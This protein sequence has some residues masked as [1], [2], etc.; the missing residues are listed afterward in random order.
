MW[1][2]Q[3]HATALAASPYT[4]PISGRQFA[5]VKPRDLLR[6]CPNDPKRPQWG[7]DDLVEGD[8]IITDDPGPVIDLRYVRDESFFSKFDVM[9]AE[10]L[11]C[12]IAVETADEMTQ[13]NVKKSTLE[14]QYKLAI[15]DARLVNAIEAYANIEPDE[16]E[17]VTCRSGATYGFGYVR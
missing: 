17:W 1:H 16:D 15:A 4:L 10:A 6:I 5:Y 11:A 9:F 7:P 2:Q 3:P 12:K 8:L 14:A 13:S